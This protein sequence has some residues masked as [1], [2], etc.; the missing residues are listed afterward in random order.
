MLSRCYYTMSL[1]DIAT[2]DS[3]EKLL[4]IT[5][6]ISL[7]HLVGCLVVAGE[8]LLLDLN[9]VILKRGNTLLQ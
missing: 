1:L 9:Q 4:V 6:G 2:D 3:Q 7:Y 8:K 5:R